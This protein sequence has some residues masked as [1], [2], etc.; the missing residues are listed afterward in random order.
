MVVCG[1]ACNGD[2]EQEPLAGGGIRGARERSDVMGL[3]RHWSRAGPR[4]VLGRQRGENRQS[5][6]ID[7]YRRRRHRR[8]GGMTRR[9][10]RCRRKATVHFIQRRSFRDRGWPTTEVYTTIKLFPA[11]RVSPIESLLLDLVVEHR[12]EL[13]FPAR[14]GSHS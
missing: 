7:G 9:R 14:T 3:R 1:G 12:L 2:G 4:S 13:P 5:I 6:F 8:L 11:I 10:V